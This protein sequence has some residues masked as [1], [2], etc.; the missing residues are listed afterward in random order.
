MIP[1]I[2]IAYAAFEEMRKS[3]AQKLVTL[4]ALADTLA[5]VAFII[6]GINYLVHYK[7]D[8]YGCED[9]QKICATQSFFSC[10]V[11]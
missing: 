4:I 9:F 1:L 7:A 10:L 5:A 2:L 11:I 6:G 8:Y 3:T